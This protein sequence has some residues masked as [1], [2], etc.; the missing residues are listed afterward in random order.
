ML[1]L[2][3]KNCNYPFAA[4][5]CSFVDRRLCLW[6]QAAISERC[7]RFWSWRS[8]YFSR[9]LRGLEAAP[10]RTHSSCSSAASGPS[11]PSPRPDDLHWTWNFPRS[12][13]TNSTST[14][15]P[16]CSAS[17]ATWHHSDA[18]STSRCACGADW[19][20]LLPFASSNTA[21]QLIHKCSSQALQNGFGPLSWSSYSRYW[22]DWSA[23]ALLWRHQGHDSTSQSS[24]SSTRWT[25]GC[26]CGSDSSGCSNASASSWL[27]HSLSIS[28]THSRCRF[29]LAILDSPSSHSFPFFQVHY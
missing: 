26:A 20:V 17:P 9:W 1:L 27:C 11:A 4:C 2:F 8:R 12:W 10:D 24:G 28:R 7:R 23:S 29:R 15:P 13:S 5:R 18:C 16:S 25:S 14:C 21:F 19:R 3:E 6:G 22:F